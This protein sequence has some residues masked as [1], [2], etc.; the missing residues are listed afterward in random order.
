VYKS[1]YLIIACSPWQANKMEFSPKLSMNRKLLC[2]R[3]FMGSYIK[4]FLLY[5][6]AYWK[7]K[8]LSG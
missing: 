7:E 3:S 4:M 6:R 2:Q 5:K 1:D 8:G